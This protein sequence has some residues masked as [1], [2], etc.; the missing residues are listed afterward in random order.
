[1]QPKR[2]T[3]P[4]QLA[5]SPRRGLRAETISKDMYEDVVVAKQDD[6]KSPGYRKESMRTQNEQFAA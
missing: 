4:T 6:G 5:Q 1:M 2:F 3:V